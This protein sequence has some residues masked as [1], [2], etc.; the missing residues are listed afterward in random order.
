MCEI[1][2]KTPCDFR[3]PNAEPLK[4]VYKC[5]WCGNEILEGDD[6]YM[7]EDCPVCEDCIDDSKRT[8]EIDEY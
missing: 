5:D 8:A 2:R 7:I 6:Y 4:L 1:C 3:C